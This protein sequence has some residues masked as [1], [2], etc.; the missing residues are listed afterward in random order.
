M[1]SFAGFLIVL[2]IALYVFAFV[3]GQYTKKKMLARGSAR[4]AA[5]ECSPISRPPIRPQ[6]SKRQFHARHY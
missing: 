1:R 3:Y 2:I 4:R 5:A 6:S